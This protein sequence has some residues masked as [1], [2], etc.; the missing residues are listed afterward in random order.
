MLKEN[1]RG[2]L[3]FFKNISLS[4]LCFVTD[5]VAIYNRYATVGAEFNT[6]GKR[7]PLIIRP[8]TP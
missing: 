7:I 1:C 8:V 2:C 3:S 6:H 5:M 4:S